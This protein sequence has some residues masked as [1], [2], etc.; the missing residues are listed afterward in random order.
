M[1]VDLLALVLPRSCAGCGAEDPLF[2]LCCLCDGQLESP[3]R[4]VRPCPP[5]LDMPPAWA[6]A[7]YEGAVRAVI[8]AAK[9]HGRPGLTSILAR[10]L[11]R[12]M[13][14]SAFALPSGTGP[15][16]A[17]PVP[18]SRRSRR[19]RR[20]R[21]MER[22]SRRAVAIASSTNPQFRYVPALSHARVVDDQAGLTATERT[23]NVSGAFRVRW[24]HAPAV[25]GV[26]VL[27]LDDIITTGSTLT[28]AARALRDA[29]ADAV[30]AAAIAFTVRRFVSGTA[31]SGQAGTASSAHRRT[32]HSAHTRNSTK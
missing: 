13:L 10:A 28:A 19:V 26:R 30:S 6:V 27:L 32:A 1:A 24:R 3:A 5:P 12:S 25:R 17:V 11:A 4:P 15:I 8:L 9:E 21:F 18:S 23:V 31:S 14:A 16:L 7:P 20:D 29:G 2:P 22:L